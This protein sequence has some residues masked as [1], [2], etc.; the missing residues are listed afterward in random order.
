MD[1]HEVTRNIQWLCRDCCEKLRET[2]GRTRSGKKYNIWEAGR[3]QKDGECFLCHRQK[4][5]TMYE[6]EDGEAKETRARRQ[7]Y[8]DRGY[9]RKK[10]T[11]ARYRRW[12]NEA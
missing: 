6:L 12:E 1:E 7:A 9:V 3:W 2:P 10:D 4:L 11:R 5:L 8:R